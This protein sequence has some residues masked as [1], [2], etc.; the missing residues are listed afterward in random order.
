MGSKIFYN[1]KIARKRNVKGFEKRLKK[2]KISYKQ[3][4]LTKDK[5]IL[6]IEG[7]FAYVMWGNTYNL[8]NKLSKDIELFLK[9][10]IPK[11]KIIPRKDVQQKLF[12]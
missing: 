6:R 2:L 8:R 11:Q 3:G 10:T 4:N 1:Y 5:F 9:N 7:W 12:V